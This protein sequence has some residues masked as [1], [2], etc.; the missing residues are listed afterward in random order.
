VLVAA[1]VAAGEVDLAEE[2]GAV[3]SDVDQVAGRTLAVALKPGQALRQTHLK[4][5]VWFSAGETIKLVAEGEGFSLEGEGVAL[6]NGV[7]GQI[8][9]VR[10]ESGRVLTGQPAG[11]RRMA[12]I[13]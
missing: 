4:A 9:R 1:D 3:L 10:V 8:A 13:L 7:E 6:S 11:P 12:L 2:S 5:R